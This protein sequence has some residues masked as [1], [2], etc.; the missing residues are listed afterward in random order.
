MNMI[1]IGIVGGTGYT[2]VELLRLISQH[3]NAQLHTI[4]SRKEA[5]IRVDHLFP[6]LRGYIDTQFTDTLCADLTDCD[7][8]FY[9]TP[10]GV[11]MQDAPN[12]LKKGVK[13]IDLAADF[14]LKNADIFQYWYKLPHSCPDLLKEAVYGLPELNRNAISQARLIGNPGCYPTTIQLGYAP[15]LSAGLIDPGHLVANCVSGISGAGKKSEI[16]FLFAE[17][18]DNFKAYGLAGHRHHP[19]TVAQLE[20]INILQATQAVSLIFTPH[21]MP[22][23]RGMHSTLYATLNETG[24]EQMGND[25]NVLQKMFEAFYANEPFIDVMPLGSIPDTRSVRGSNK[26]RI[27]V[28]RLNNSS[29]IIILVV[30]DNLVKGASGQAIQCMNL[31]FGLPEVTGLNILPVSP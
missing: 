18:S 9:A 14:R 10:H 29:T 30:Q 21:L 15:L 27:A 2:G 28:H 19:E 13:V 5:G 12:L 16:D 25:S 20:R 7:V 6:S 8:V 17:T 31:M 1:K 11:A 3:P 24:L 23:I 22:A 26:L 4:T